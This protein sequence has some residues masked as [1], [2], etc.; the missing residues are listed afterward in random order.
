MC[1]A[2]KVCVGESDSWGGGMTFHDMEC[3]CIH[4]YCTCM[5]VYMYCTCMYVYMYCAMH[6]VYAPYTELTF[7]STCAVC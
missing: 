1:G 7:T 6:S 3:K 5:Y 4:V 2:C